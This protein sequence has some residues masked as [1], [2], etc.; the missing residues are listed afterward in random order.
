MRRAVEDVNRL[1]KWAQRKIQSL[2]MHLTE[3]KN[4][5]LVISSKE[6]TDTRILRGP[7]DAPMNLPN[8]SQIEFTPKN[9]KSIEVALRH[10]DNEGITVMAS[11]GSLRVMPWATN[12]V[13]I[14]VA[15]H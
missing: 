13:R 8:R 15:E 12:V 2:E 7:F 6:S 3:A 9:G 14:Y 1:P 4:E 5:V 11:H 10:D